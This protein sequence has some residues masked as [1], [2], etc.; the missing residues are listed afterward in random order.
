MPVR[1]RGGRIRR[2]RSPIREGPR[3]G[4]RPPEPG[5][6]DGEV[7][8]EVGT[9]VKDYFQENLGAHSKPLPCP[10]LRHSRTKVGGARLLPPPAREASGGEADSGRCPERGGGR[11]PE[12]LR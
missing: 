5:G 8:H 1:V 3:I 7:K 12:A 2:G 9:Y 11:F 6:R 4:S 10:G